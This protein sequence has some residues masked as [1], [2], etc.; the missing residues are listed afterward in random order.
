MIKQ[1]ATADTAKAGIKSHIINSCKRQ[2]Q[3]KN[4]K[5][6]M[7]QIEHIDI[8]LVITINVNSLNTTIKMQRL[9]T[10]D[11]VPRSNFM[12]SEGSQT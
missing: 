1:R 5:E 6:W 12:V 3:R 7:G 8:L 2:G 4:N 11:K 9:F 10:L